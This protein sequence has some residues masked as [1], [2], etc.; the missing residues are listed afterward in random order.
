MADM[1][2]F[3]Q[4]GTILGALTKNKLRFD[5]SASQKK[6]VGLICVFALAY[7]M[8]E[9]FIIM[10][11]YGF[12]T[13]LSVM[14]G[15]LL[16]YIDVLK[17]Q[18][19]FGILL[20]TAAIVLVFGVVYLVA[21][22]YLA[23]DT[24]F[25][26]TL[27][28][29]PSVVFA[30]KIAF[31]YLFEVV[32]VAAVA[33]PAIIVYGALVDA[34][35][36]YYFISIL[37]LPIAPAFP[38]VISA[39]FAVPVMYIA[40]KVRN[41]NIIP[42]IFYCLLFGGFIVLYILPMTSMSSMIESEEVTQD[43]VM[44]FVRVV[45]VIGYILY[46]YTALSS[47]AF[48]L[49]T[50]GFGDGGST[51]VNI[52]IFVGISAA[53]IIILLLLGKFMYSQAAKANNQ[54]D[55][56]RAKKG[57]YKSSSQI[58]TLVKREYL[59]ALRT[60]STMFQCFFTLLFPIIFAVIMSM[61]FKNMFVITEQDGTSINAMF[62]SPLVFS[63]VFIMMPVLSNAA[64]TSFSREGIGIEAL[65]S[66]PVSPKTLV[67]AKITAWSALGMPIGVASAVIVNIFMFDF[68]Q[69]F[70]SI[71]AFLWLPF[72]YIAFGVL[73]DM[74]SPKLVWS[75]PIQAIKHNTHSTIGQ[76]IGMGA[77]FVIFILYFVLAISTEA[78]SST[79]MA[80]VWALIY[81]TLVVFLVIDIILYRRINAY[82][83]KMTV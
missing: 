46:P 57:E 5:A 40:R 60:P 22:L 4:F 82:Y 51:A 72:V 23:K 42:I 64:I 77:G 70:L 69:L 12:T 18:L 9:A 28:V 33:L 54:T 79:M 11:L 55:N 21:T 81:C 35:V 7:I 3:K 34:W 27:P 49:D 62:M 20:V 66:M 10:M 44:S 48:K 59:L 71:L 53:L 61:M 50:F 45:T 39:I 19:F 74:S 47:A 80:I 31:V 56:S 17:Q 67:K 68:L 75:D 30:A 41:R 6:K 15:Y 13:V 1:N 73:W 78:S 43:Q 29:K 52:L 2:G 16:Y 8:A 58:K 76:F 38:L 32:I 83:E 24:D 63:I 26:S 14:S 36:G 65:K 37:C 25:Y